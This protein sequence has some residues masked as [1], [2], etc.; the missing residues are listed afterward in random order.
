MTTTAHHDYSYDDDP[1]DPDGT[2]DPDDPDGTDG[3]DGPGDLD[4]PDG[5]GDHGDDRRDRAREGLEHLQS[6]ARELIHA[7]RAVLDVA[8]DLVDDPGTVESLVG[9]VSGLG[10]L[11]R[12]R[13]RAY[14][15][16]AGDHDP[17]HAVDP[18]GAGP[19][20]EGTSELAVERIPVV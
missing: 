15:G 14:S 5:P 6:A 13:A 20:A 4:V 12:S 10:D 8:E 11:V 1:D 18:S 3:L 9:A 16:W 2:D 17:T 19:A 7:A